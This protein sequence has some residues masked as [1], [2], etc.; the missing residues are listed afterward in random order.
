MRSRA[1]RPVSY[2]LALCVAV[3]P[4]A[5]AAQ[6]GAVLEPGERIEGYVSQVT[7]REA[8]KVSDALDAAE[9]LWRLR[10]SPEKA[11]EAREAFARIVESEPDLIDA[12]LRLAEA[13]WWLAEMEEVRESDAALDGYKACYEAAERAV[14]LDKFEP[15]GHY[16][17]ARCRNEFRLAKGLLSSA[18]HFNR[19]LRRLREAERM[20]PRMMQGGLYAIRARMILAATPIVRLLLNQGPKDALALLEKQQDIA[21]ACFASRVLHGDVLLALGR[22]EQAREQWLYVL[23]TA[24]NLVPE[25]YNENLKVQ[26]RLR[27][28]VERARRSKD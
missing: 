26:E 2:A 1:V 13:S 18:V 25:C 6:E 3:G 4:L 28:D 5:A 27:R 14:R 9:R 12:Q 8:R 16:W 21:Q 20:D 24:A 22:G 15:R 7:G 17:S 23:R 10:E 11:R 19:T